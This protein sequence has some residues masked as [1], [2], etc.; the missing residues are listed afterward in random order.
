MSTLTRR[1]W[2]A[3]REKLGAQGAGACKV[4]KPPGVET[5]VT[6]VPPVCPFVSMVGDVAAASLVTRAIACDV[7][8]FR[9]LLTFAA[10]LLPEA[11]SN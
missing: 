4:W 6:L 10:S 9:R 3:S 11:F 5:V 7:I 2:G 1:G 8:P